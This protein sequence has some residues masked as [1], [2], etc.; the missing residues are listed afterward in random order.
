MHDAR[1]VLTADAQPFMDGAFVVQLL[2]L[3][4]VDIHLVNGERISFVESLAAQVHTGGLLVLEFPCAKTTVVR[5]APT[6]FVHH[7]PLHLLGVL[8]GQLSAESIHAGIHETTKD[9]D[10][11]SSRDSPS[12]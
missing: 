4:S 10:E 11:R 6:Q 3:Q 9:L 5:L 1:V 8:C 12:C 2:S 7:L